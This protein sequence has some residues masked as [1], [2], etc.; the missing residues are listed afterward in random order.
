MLSVKEIRK[1]NTLEL[2]EF[3]ERKEFATFV[4]IEYTLLNQYLSANAPKNIGNNNAKKITDAFNVPEGWL[5][6][7]HTDDNMLSSEGDN[8]KILPKGK[9][10]QLAVL[11]Y[12]KASQFC[13]YHDD[14]IADEYLT[15]EGDY[16]D[17]AYI[18]IIEG[19]SMEPDFYAGE[20]VIV[21]PDLQ[22]NPSDFVIAL[23]H[24]DKKTTF[25]KYRPKGFDE[26]GVEYYQLIPSNPDY[27]IIDSRHEP[28]SIC[29]VAVERKQK[30]R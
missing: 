19:K 15:V 3:F 24:N 12:V 26:H 16:G 6:H 7:E 23:S 22:P 13:E 9:V 11:N 25:K 27:P 20:M 8:F 14:A 30:L 2:L 5:D 10:R 18:V 17:N 4:G 1:R 29:A 28:F 21:D